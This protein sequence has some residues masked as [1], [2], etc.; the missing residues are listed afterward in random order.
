MESIIKGIT[1]LR[2]TLVS[3]SDATEVQLVVL[4]GLLPKA[5]DTAFVKYYGFE[6]IPG[7]DN[8][9]KAFAKKNSLLRL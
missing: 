9:E 6:G 2:D 4:K 1:D 7:P 5:R 8:F 3:E